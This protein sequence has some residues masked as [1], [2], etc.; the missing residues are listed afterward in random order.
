MYVASRKDAKRNTDCRL[1]LV[2]DGDLDRDA[3]GPSTLSKVQDLTE[4]L[5]ARAL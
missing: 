1:E 5:E 3:P 2:A 4:G